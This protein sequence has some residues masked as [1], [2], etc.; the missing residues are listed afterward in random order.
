MVVYSTRRRKGGHLPTSKGRPR[1]RARVTGALT[2]ARSFPEP[3]HGSMRFKGSWTLPST[4]PVR[5]Q[6]PLFRH[7]DGWRRAGARSPVPG[8]ERNP[9]ARSLDGAWPGGAIAATILAKGNIS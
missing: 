6:A 4:I 8:V 7:C 9:P 5:V 1:V 2:R 3:P